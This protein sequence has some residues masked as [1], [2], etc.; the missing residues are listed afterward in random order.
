MRGVSLLGAGLLLGFVALVDWMT[1]TSSQATPADALFRYGTN[2]F[3]AGNYAQAA[4][5]FGQAAA[6]EPAGGTLQNLGIAE[7]EA[8]RTGPAIIAWEQSL[9]LDPFNQASRAN[10]RFARRAA[11]LE[12]P[13]LSWSEVVSTWLPANW[14]A[15]V[16]ALSLW[17]AVGISTVPGMLRRSRTGWQQAVAAFGLAIFLLSIPAQAGVNSRAQLG[18]ILF[19]EVPLRLTPTAEAQLLTRL[20]AGEAAH[21]ER[22]KGAYLL[23]RTSHSTGWIQ[24]DQFKL[25]CSEPGRIPMAAE[26]VSANNPPR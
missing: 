24:R 14:W 6:L 2:A 21:L 13:D 23:V 8:G 11:Q 18:I 17:V 3:S 22:S 10:L 16:A 15:W 1:I 4:G 26:S 5:A 7:W 9:W 20:P 25:V 12:A 19:K